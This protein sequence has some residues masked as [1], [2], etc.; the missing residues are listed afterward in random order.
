MLPPGAFYQ[1]YPADACIRPTIDLSVFGKSKTTH[2]TS[3]FN[4]YVG[5]LPYLN[6]YGFL[7]FSTAYAVF[8][9]RISKIH[10]GREH[11][12]A[13]GFLSALP[14]GCMHPPYNLF[15]CIW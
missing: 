11:A 7:I 6:L 12:P 5:G 2:L 4:V 15:I 1:H 14:G 9:D 13:G 8:V 10:V 3:V